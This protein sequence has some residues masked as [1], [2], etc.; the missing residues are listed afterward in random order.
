MA[1]RPD[2]FNLTIKKIFV[3][4]TEIIF[5]FR[6][7]IEAIRNGTEI[8]KI[9]LQN[10]LTSSLYHELLYEIKKYKIPYQ[11][12]PSEKINRL[13]KK[14]HQ[15]AI[16]YISPISYYSLE[17]LIPVIYE[18][19]IVPFLL[20]LDSITDVRNFGAIARTAVCAGVDAL[21]IPDR[22]SVTVNADAIKAS[23]GA[24]F[25]IPVC[26]SNNLISVVEYLKNSGIHIIAACEKANKKIYSTDLRIPL[27]FILGAEDKGINPT[28]LKFADEQI[29]ITVSGAIASLNVS[30]AAGIMIYETR[31]QR[32]FRCS[33]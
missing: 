9:L 11:Y 2:F 18:K 16:A 32:D 1:E 30:V 5:G 6:A 33:Y 28:L 4:N 14:N 24:L 26:R 29:S 7:I 13:T 31:R 15:G 21:I 10:G 3:R 25:N 8:I 27:C 22:D 20:M 12:I 23:A 17:N 19:G